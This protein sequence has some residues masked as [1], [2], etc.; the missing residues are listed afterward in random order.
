MIECMKIILLHTLT[1]EEECRR[2]IMVRKEPVI[3]NQ[4]VR[5]CNVS[6]LITSKSN[7]RLSLN[8]CSRDTKI[9]SSLLDI[10]I[11]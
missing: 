8:K 3:K 10:F 1:Q 11:G 6:N 2:C 7:L 9:R 5:A 4:K